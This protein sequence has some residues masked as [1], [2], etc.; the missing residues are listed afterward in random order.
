[1]AIEGLERDGWTLPSKRGRECSGILLMALVL[2]FIS[3]LEHDIWRFG[4]Q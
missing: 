4:R 3:C 1:M 2:G